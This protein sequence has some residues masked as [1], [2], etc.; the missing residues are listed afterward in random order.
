MGIIIMEDIMNIK[1]NIKL[2]TVI[3]IAVSS[4]LSGCGETNTSTPTSTK[5]QIP[6]PT[7][8]LEPTDTPL[9]TPTST[10]EIDYS[11]IYSPHELNSVSWYSVSVNGESYGIT[12]FAVVDTQTLETGEFVYLIENRDDVQ[13]FTNYDYIEF[14]PNAV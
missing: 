14:L 3:L 7:M 13:A 1:S 11:E 10:P 8:T 9:P 6:S 5:T 2:L 4:W 12:S